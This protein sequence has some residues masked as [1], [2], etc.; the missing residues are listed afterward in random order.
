MSAPESPEEK[1]LVGQLLAD[2]YRIERELGEGAMGTVY[3]GEHLRFGRL[4]AIKVLHAGMDR[5][6]EATER[7]L[8]GARNASRINHPN[9]CTVYDFGESDDG[10]QFLAME[11]VEGETLADILEREGSLP[12]ARAAEIVRQTASA[13]D[14][15]HELGI[16]HRDLK[17]GNVM[18]ARTRD[19]RDR[20]KVVDFDIAKGSAEGEGAEV[21]RTGFVVGT[22]EYMSPEQLIG[23]PLDGRSDTYSLALLFVRTLTGRL[24][25]RAAS[26]Q[27]L[28]V[29]RLTQDPL[30]LTE[31]APELDVPPGVQAALD[32]ALQRRREDRP[33][34]AGAFAAALVSATPGAAGTGAATAGGAEAGAPAGSR[35]PPTAIGRRPAD[36]APAPAPPPAAGGRS[37]GLKVGGGIAALAVV[38]FLAFRIAA[39]GGGEPDMPVMPDVDPAGTSSV[40]HDDAPEGTTS[41]PPEE[42]GN[43]AA[44]EG[45]TTPE[46][47]ADPP[48]IRT[49]EEPAPTPETAALRPLPPAAEVEDQLFR[50]LTALTNLPTAMTFRA[51]RDTALVAWEES[52]HPD[53][54]RALAAYVTASAFEAEG[55]AGDALAWAR[56]AVSLAPENR[57]YRA[58][59]DALGG[60]TR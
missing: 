33:P 8:R 41:P 39:G 58:L 34:T 55:A 16:V 32:H 22:P 27:D 10:V 54:V 30:P 57:G 15:A 60:A 35:I 56:R 11:Y 7:F 18:V 1:G 36:G 14:A 47:Q 25:A 5:D 49:D 31:V 21:T 45:T 6:R 37:L 3:L 13:L 2:R 46:P 48:P 52:R 38:G 28:M 29:E 23:D 59:L 4:D 50:Q 9:V 51:V 24:P 42:S 40:V 12:L 26:T 44:P 17:P 20:V 19:G 53:G 43:V